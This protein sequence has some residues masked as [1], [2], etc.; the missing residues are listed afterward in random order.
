MSCIYLVNIC[1]ACVSKKYRD[2]HFFLAQNNLSIEYY[3]LPYRLLT[4]QTSVTLICEKI[5]CHP[6]MLSSIMIKDTNKNYKQ[7]I[8]GIFTKMNIHCM[9]NRKPECCFDLFLDTVS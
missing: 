6:T 8:A 3:T 9:F 5:L 1:F 7:D 4:G 2:K